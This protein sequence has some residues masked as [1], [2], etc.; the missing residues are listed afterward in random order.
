MLCAGASLAR[1]TPAGAPWGS[2]PCPRSADGQ[3]GGADPQR[4][5]LAGRRRSRRAL[6]QH[7]RQAR[8][9][10]RGRARA[11]ARADR[12]PGNQRVGLR[13][14]RRSRERRG[15]RPR[16]GTRRRPPTGPVRVGRPD[17]PRARAV[18]APGPLR[19]VPRGALPPRPGVATAGG[20][21]QAGPRRERASSPAAHERPGKLAGHRFRV[22]TSHPGGAPAFRGR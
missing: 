9:V 1:S 17:R 8:G 15:H 10:G 7:P 13:P 2:T 22:R 21:R 16:H 6:L 20:G 18:G 12:L 14:R 4:E 11:G 5:L 3:P 19:R